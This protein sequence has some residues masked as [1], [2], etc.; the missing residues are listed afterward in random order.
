MARGNEKGRV[1]RAIRYIRDAFFT[2]RKFVDLADLNR[3]ALEWA[4]ERAST[5]PWVEDKSRLVRD[6][7]AEEQD[8]LL[9]LPDDPFPAHERVEVEAGKTPYIRFDLNDYS[10]PHDRIRRTLTVV[11][12]FDTVR[13]VDGN[14]V[15]ALHARSWDRD[16]QIELP[17]H[18]V[19]LAQAKR[20]ARESRGLDRLAKA[21]PSS[22]AFLRLVAGRHQ[23]LG[24]TT[25]RLLGLLDWAGAAELEEA[26]VEV[27][28]RDTIHV[29]A[30]RQVLDRRR[31]E[32]GLPP[33]VLL[34]LA[35]SAHR[36]LVINPHS[37]ASYDTLTREDDHG[38]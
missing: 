27:L 1:E 36:D 15:L 3:H 2:A 6:A 8:K 13:V 12:D 9:P 19:R 7:F 18:L 23:N 37:L 25:A 24:A 34:S 20:R 17:E 21:A 29:G 26:L 31:T 16:Q 22:Q 4:T 32:R 28:E 33:P 10:I 30:V 5:R 35:P 38:E 14:V 11:A